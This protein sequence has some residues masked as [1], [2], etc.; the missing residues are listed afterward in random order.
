MDYNQQS[1]LEFVNN[2]KIIVQ[3]QSL[4]Y[5]NQPETASS[6]SKRFQLV[7][8]MKKQ[9]FYEDDMIDIDNEKLDQ[10]YEN[11]V[12]IQL[13]QERKNIDC[14]NQLV[15]EIY[16]DIIS[17][18]TFIL[19]QNILKVLSSFNSENL[20]QKFQQELESVSYSIE[21]KI[22][23][24]LNTFG[25]TRLQKNYQ[26][27]LRFDSDYQLLVKKYL[28]FVF[29]SMKYDEKRMKFDI[30]LYFFQDASDQKN[31][32]L[33]PE[34]WIYLPKQNEKI[35]FQ[36]LQDVVK[37]AIQSFYYSP[38]ETL[39][40]EDQEEYQFYDLN[41]PSNR[42][43]EKCQLSFIHFIRESI[44]LHE[45]QIISSKKQ[46]LIELLDQF[47]KNYHENNENKIELLV[48]Y[49][50]I[51]IQY[52]EVINDPIQHFKDQLINH[53][54]QNI[55]SY[56]DQVNNQPE[57]VSFSDLQERI[58]EFVNSY[59]LDYQ[60]YAY[61]NKIQNIIKQYKSNK[62]KQS[63]VKME[64]SQTSI[65]EI[66]Q[67]VSSQFVAQFKEVLTQSTVK[68]LFQYLKENKLTQVQQNSINQKE[69]TL[70]LCKCIALK[71][72]PSQFKKY[73]QQ[74][75]TKQQMSMTII[76]SNINNSFYES[77][78]D[79][80]SLSNSSKPQIDRGNEQKILN[81]NNKNFLLNN[82][83]NQNLLRTEEK[84]IYREQ[85]RDN[86]AFFENKKEIQNFCNLFLE[87]FDKECKLQNYSY[88][89]F[90][91]QN[92]KPDLESK[93]HYVIRFLE[94]GYFAIFRE[95]IKQAKVIVNMQSNQQ[96]DYYNNIVNI[97]S[98]TGYKLNMIVIQINEF[99]MLMQMI[100]MQIQ[101]NQKAICFSPL[102]H[103]LIY[104]IQN[105]FTELSS[106][107]IQNEVLFEFMMNQLQKYNQEFSFYNK[108]QNL[109]NLQY[110]GNQVVLKK[111]IKSVDWQD[112]LYYNNI[113]TNKLLYIQNNKK[114]FLILDEHHQSS[115]NQNKQDQ[116]YK[117]E[118]DEYQ[119][120]PSECEEVYL[121]QKIQKEEMI[122]L[123]KDSG[124]T[125]IQILISLFGFEL[126]KDEQNKNIFF[127][128]SLKEKVLATDF[129]FP[130]QIIYCQELSIQI[131]QSSN[132]FNKLNPQVQVVDFKDFQSKNKLI[133]LNA[134]DLKQNIISLLL[135]VLEG[136]QKESIVNQLNCDFSQNTYILNISTL[137]KNLK[138]I[139]E[140]SIN[141]TINLMQKFSLKSSVFSL[142]LRDIISQKNLFKFQI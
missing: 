34:N 93:N 40:E 14:Q 6:A 79:K 77:K 25:I 90:Y 137:Q 3:Q 125:V 10:K 85:S 78:P 122:N 113:N 98:E 42:L 111:Q 57:T 120:D 106:S 51:Q 1:H 39:I 67:Y 9:D 74:I 48:L 95:S 58:I 72:F 60:I 2:N 87:K 23:E 118:Y 124:M 44:Q 7:Q 54:Q 97:L 110:Y 123:I 71:V 84:T 16:Q 24:Y 13:Q 52:K 114:Y 128:K 86:E 61:L 136:Y 135:I 140:N 96:S 30:N 108:C 138:P 70:L 35:Y 83:Y 27:L 107:Q 103:F 12:V 129:Q 81:Q 20:S 18:Q 139:I 127:T 92:S 76:Q 26:L 11:N 88:Q 5:A 73:S 82:S 32:R 56:M 109:Y 46:N 126:E 29:K 101:Q 117:Y 141:T 112:G 91:D 115:Q 130:Q 15:N 94:N 28:H 100:Q 63:E 89:I 8:P 64:N 65:Q 66:L 50:K 36:H 22:Y 104:S 75:E 33:N 55:N 132:N 121:S 105:K 43:Q 41:Y 119:I 99:E 142:I 59:Y 102:I 68:A 69:L 31:Q 4:D 134:Q 38:F 19:L 37:Q 131:S 133:I 49:K 17:E 116:Y 45:F 62:S 47:F 80:N 53:M 21:Q